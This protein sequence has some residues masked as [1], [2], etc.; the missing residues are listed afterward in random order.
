[1]LKEKMVTTLILVF[2]DWKKEFH[3][4]V[5]AS[6]IAMG[7]M[8]I[9]VNEGELDH[10]IAFSSRKMSKAEKN[11]LMTEHKE[12]DMVYTLQNFKHYLLGGHFKMYTDHSTLNNLVNKPML[13]GEEYADGCCYFKSMISKK[14]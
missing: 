4:H 2:L 3:V 14:L 5:D 6:S 11:Y 1:V 13:G 8:L 12:L 10:L 7:T 9:Q